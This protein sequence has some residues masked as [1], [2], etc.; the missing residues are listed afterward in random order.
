MSVNA[1]RKHDYWVRQWRSRIDYNAEENRV[2]GVLIDFVL[3]MIHYARNRRL[4]NRIN[5]IQPRGQQLYNLIRHKT[6]LLV[7]TPMSIEARPVQPVKD[8]DP[9]MISRRVIEQVIENPRKRYHNVRHRKV[10]TGLAAG[11]GAVAIE[12]NGDAGGTVFR[13]LDARKL[14]PTPGFLDIHDP[15]MP[16]L[17]E[18]VPMRLSAVRAMGWRVPKDLH[19]DNWVPDNERGG[20]G[21][22][23]EVNFD[24]AGGQGAPQ[25]GD[26]DRDDGIVTILKCYSRRDPFR[27]TRTVRVP[28]TLSQEHWYWSDD[29]DARV[30]LSDSP[31]PP[32]PAWRLVT[33]D[34]DERDLYR[35]PEGYL[36]IVAPFYEGQEPLDESGWLPGAVND[37]VRLRS[38]PYT[39]FCPYLHPEK[40]A[41]LADG[42]LNHSLQVIDNASWRAAWEQMR[43][44]SSI[45][46]AP[47]GGLFSADRRAFELTDQPFQIA[48]TNDAVTGERIKFFQGPGM[49]SAMPAF[50]SILNQQWSFIGTGDITMPAE[51]SRDIAVGTIQAM[52][53]S[54]DLPVQLHRQVLTSDEAIEYGIV[55]DYERAYRSDKELVQWV[56]DTGELGAA[57]V[58]G[59][60]LIDVNVNLTASPDWRAAS[61]D[62]IQA[63]AQFVGQMQNTPQL[64]ADLAPHAGLP[65]EAVRAIRKT[66]AGMLQQAPPPELTPEGA[67]APAA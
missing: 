64:L 4:D 6:S 60:D 32:D 3:N 47:F 8:A 43:Q 57:Y 61:A 26:W 10:L 39:E 5:R 63:L 50:R 14:F 58:S 15:C 28:R 48:Y 38:F 49:N 27:Q 31:V 13:N 7:T 44:A 23:H 25:D 18:Q 29:R 2:Y 41:G 42:E 67:A 33:M 59:A 22:S 37:R 52:Q 65:P 17:I 35:Y 40:R 20:A 46:V 21:D 66:V 9:A 24:G 54:G 19:A 34:E 30:L 53:Q 51:R 36:C 62:R 12:Y 16:D 55:L 11:R 56:T 45:M 1:A